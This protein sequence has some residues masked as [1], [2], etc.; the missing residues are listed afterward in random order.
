ML[1]GSAGYYTIQ[2]AHR[3]SNTEYQLHEA[4]GLGLHLPEG[5]AFFLSVLLLFAAFN[6]L[7]TLV[8]H[9]LSGRLL[10]ILMKEWSAHLTSTFLGPYSCIGHQSTT[11]HA[12]SGCLD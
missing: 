5:V 12:E 2:L 6:S 11:N 4:R 10:I 9:P 3:T 1:Q 8:T 7:F